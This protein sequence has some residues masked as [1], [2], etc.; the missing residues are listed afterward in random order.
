MG[1]NLGYLFS[2][3]KILGKFHTDNAAGNRIYIIDIFA[4][5]KVCVKN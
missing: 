4:Y 3:R 5:F 1:S 2:K